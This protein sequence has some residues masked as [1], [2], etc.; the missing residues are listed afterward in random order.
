MPGYRTPLPAVLA[1]LLEAAVN[2]LLA[3]DVN[4]AERLQRL[5][6]RMVALQLEG[7]GIDLFFSFTRHR[8]A[9]GLEADRDADTVI[10]GSPPALF[11]MAVPDEAGS[12]GRPGSRVSISGDAT[13]ARDLER[14]FSRLDP[15]WEAE[16]SR[17]FGDVLGHQ[18]AA[19]ARGTVDQLRRTAATLEEWTG[20]WL[21]QAEGP[22]AQPTDIREF[23]AAVD[24]LR[25]ATD[26]LEARLRILRERR[27][28]QSSD[29]AIH[30]GSDGAIDG[31]GD[32][33]GDEGTG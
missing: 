5:D 4:S 7:V 29:D 32:K 15:D 3:T 1:G 28:A 6:G 24:A 17:W 25:D 30:D 22:L 14:L 26:R 9:V 2:R 16:M 27:A 18:V 23:S 20:E 31:A 8:V 11:A 13:L 19:G 33:D 12:W 21:R 10:A